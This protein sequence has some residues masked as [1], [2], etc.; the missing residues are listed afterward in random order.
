[1]THHWK[2]Q[3]STQTSPLKYIAVRPFVGAPHCGGPIL[4]T[5]PVYTRPRPPPSMR[6]KTCSTQWLS[7]LHLLPHQHGPLTRMTC[8]SSNQKHGFPGE[9][10]RPF[11]KNR[12]PKL[13]EHLKCSGN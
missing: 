9:S 13:T 3:T 5:L 2:G 1:M 12:L 11:A 7:S 4:W 10:H 8:S 6:T